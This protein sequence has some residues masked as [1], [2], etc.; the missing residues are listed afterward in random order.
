MVVAAQRQAEK[1]ITVGA[2]EVERSSDESG[3]VPGAA[4]SPPREVAD[5]PMGK[6]VARYLQRLAP[7]GSTLVPVVDYPDLKAA[8]ASYGTPDGNLITLA[9][10]RLTNPVPLQAITQRP[11]TEGLSESARRG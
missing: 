9:A 6:A 2:D 4:L 1:W 3:A 11:T 10:Q 5:G 8:S 7:A